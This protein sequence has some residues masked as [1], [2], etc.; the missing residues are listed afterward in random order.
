M[1]FLSYSRID[2]ENLAIKL[3][4]QLVA[5]PPSIH[6]WLDQRGLQPG[7]DWDEQLVNAL[8]DCDGFLWPPP[9]RFPAP[10]SSSRNW[11]LPSGE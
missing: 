11:Q 2:G 3:A 8:H 1:Y 10:F 4:D 9:C 6:V 7:I 5:G